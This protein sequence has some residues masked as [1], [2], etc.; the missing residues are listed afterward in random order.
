MLISGGQSILF[1]MLVQQLLW[2][3]RPIGKKI[4]M[5]LIGIN[6]NDTAMTRFDDVRIK[7]IVIT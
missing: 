4:T 2:P 6:K 3:Q 7:K 5:V 1:G